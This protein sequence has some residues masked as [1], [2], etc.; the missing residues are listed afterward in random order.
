MHPSLYS[1]QDVGSEMMSSHILTCFP[2]S[3]TLY[4]QA[5]PHVERRVSGTYFHWLITQILKL[6]IFES[7]MLHY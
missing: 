6:V 4:V 2:T 5:V 3:G 7:L 1:F